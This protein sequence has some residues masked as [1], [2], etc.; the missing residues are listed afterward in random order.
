M[1]V[2]EEDEGVCIFRLRE[3]KNKRSKIAKKVISS[4]HAA[5]CFLSDITV[6]AVTFD[7]ACLNHCM[8]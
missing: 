5:C 1:P 7:I 4:I 3:R 2:K 8:S 6:I